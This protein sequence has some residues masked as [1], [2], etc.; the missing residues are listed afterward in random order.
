MAADVP[1]PDVALMLRVKRGDRGAFAELVERWKHPVVGFVYRTLPDADEAEDLTQ[2]TFVQLWK[3][4][5]RYQPSAR[6]STFLFT[7]A[8]NLCLNE[9]RRRSRHPADSLDAVAG[10]GP[11]DEGPS[12]QI[13]DR[14]QPGADAEA[15]RGEL[16]AKVEE[17]LRDLPEKQRTALV[18]CREGELS[19]EEIADVLGTSLQATKSIIHRARETLK[20][21]LKPYLGTG[22]WTPSQDGR[23][24][25]P[26]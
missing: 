18:L 8:R 7:I 4:A 21:R 16:F 26:R 12:H 20:A 14:R 11:D 13:E 9:I 6:F 23:G 15:V 5:D 24:G 17:A 2:A 1:D 19:Y 10:S 25:P 3:T 22:E